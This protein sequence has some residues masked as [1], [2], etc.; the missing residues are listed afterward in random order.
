MNKKI[1]F[2]IQKKILLLIFIALGVFGLVAARLSY[3]HY[4][5]ATIEQHKRLGVSTS[6]LVASVID[7]DRV[8]NFIKNGELASGYMNTKRQLEI[9]RDSSPNIKYVYVYKI[10][11][12]GCHVV[13]DLDP[14]ETTA[15]KP[16]EVVEFDEAFKP[17]LP[18]LLKGGRI[19][20]I[21]SDDKFGW[22]LTV[23]TPVYDNDG[24]CQCYAAVDISMEHL[25]KDTE[26]FFDNMALV[27]GLILLCILAIALLLA[28]RIITPINSMAR[29]TDNFAFDNEQAMEH[30]LEEIRRL[31]INTG[32]EVENLYQAFVKMTNDSVRYVTDIRQKNET[33]RKMHDAFLLTLADM[34]ENRDQNTG[35]HIRKTAAYVKILLEE[36]K[37]EGVYTEQLTKKYIRNVV[38]SAPLHDVG[39]INVSDMILNKPGKLTDEEFEIMKTHTTAGGRIIAS[40]IDKVPD[41]DYLYEAKNLAMYHHE[42]WNG[43]GYPSGLAGEDIP[44]SARVMA[45]ADVFDALI[46]NR[47]YK[48]GFPYEKAFGIIREER[49][50]QFD[51][52]IVDAF[53]AA[54]DQILEVADKFSEKEKQETSV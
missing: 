47:C 9:I 8:Q 52:K 37:R 23:Y 12:D 38:S 30:N 21:I 34:V 15:G 4:L 5:N 36:L 46:S 26:R 17:Y 44:L 22:L 25:R 2:S 48:K 41:S 3:E 33:I 54:E 16:G 45:V 6:A 14:D 10:L 7:A 53:F 32:D 39:K 35:D 29:T 20:P 19:D 42:K 27:F 11:P 43:K 50:R 13:F 18:T 31:N 28:R 24:T 1:K 49:G 51:P 40:L